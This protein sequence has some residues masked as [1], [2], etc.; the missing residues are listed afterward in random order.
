[1]QPYPLINFEMQK[2]YQNKPIF[3]VEEKII[4]KKMRHT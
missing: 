1:M 2:C 3:N 4:K